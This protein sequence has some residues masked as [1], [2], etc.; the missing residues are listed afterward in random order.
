[1][2]ILLCSCH[3]KMPI[4]ENFNSQIPVSLSVS[5]ASNPS[6]NTNLEGKDAINSIHVLVFTGEGSLEQT[7]LIYTV[8]ATLKEGNKFV[9]TF[10]QSKDAQDL[11]RLVVLANVDDTQIAKLQNGSTYTQIS[12]TLYEDARQRYSP[13]APVRM[14]GVV[15]R[16]EGIQI[17]ET[18][19][20]ATINLIRSVARIDIGVGNYD[21][22]TDKWS[23]EASGN[24]FILT[25]IE[26]WSPMSRNFEMPSQSKFT[27]QADG[28]PLVGSAMGSLEH[29]TTTAVQ[30]KYTDTDILTNG[31]ATYCKDIIYLPEA[32]LMGYT[33]N[34]PE[35]RNK[36]T[37]LIIGGY[38]HNPTDMVA[39]KT[40]T[41]YRVDFT[42]ASGNTPDGLLFD[43]LRNHLYRI[44]L[45]V[46]VRGAATAQ[47]AW[48]VPYTEIGII[49]ME[50]VPWEEGRIVDAPISPQPTQ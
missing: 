47:E 1:M 44:S 25:D 9:G 14:F 21:E 33:A 16:G 24:Y 13:E 17:A 6:L 50:T 32:P 30:W 5:A 15:N 40:K 49:T 11:Y 23:L 36:R 7:S 37:T 4:S 2:G 27:Y 39:A 12:E 20:L 45:N 19:S 34:Q 42:A 18:M 46:S 8:K 10:Y 38:L 26:A 28:T 3:E 35:N 22:G 31:I 41:W 48:N 29:S 43:I